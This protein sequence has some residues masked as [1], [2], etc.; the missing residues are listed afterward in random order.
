MA[1]ELFDLT[2]DELFVDPISVS[3]LETTLGGL[4]SYA[5]S[6]S[7]SMGVYPQSGYVFNK[8]IYA[9]ELGHVLSANQ[10]PK[11]PASFS[12]LDNSVLFTEMFADLLAYSLFEKIIIPV[13]G[14]ESCIDRTRYITNGQ[15]YNL[16]QEYFLDSFGMARVAK[17][18]ASKSMNNAH[19]NLKGL[20]EEI[21]RMGEFT[22]ELTTPFEPLVIDLSRVDSHQIGMPLLSFL[23]ELSV[24]T[25]MEVRDVFRLGFNKST[26]SSQEFLCNVSRE[27]EFIESKIVNYHTVRSFLQDLKAG[28]SFED[29]LVFD[30]LFNKHAI[31]KGLIFGDRTTTNSVE[32]IVKDQLRMLGEEHTCSGS[33]NYLTPPAPCSVSCKRK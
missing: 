13:E 11:L 3:F 5:G 22:V 1:A 21:N 14:E 23:K 10:N 7:I 28:L 33:V 15:S 6:R 4:G 27:E 25:K 18:C 31:E 24:K 19:S 29:Q 30:L 20:C 32:L 8:G 2:V 16:P 17:C 26:P 9:H 12:D